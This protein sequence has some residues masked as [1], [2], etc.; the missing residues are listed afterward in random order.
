MATADGYVLLA[1]WSSGMNILHIS[2][3][4]DFD[5][6]GDVDDQDIDL[7]EMC[8]SGPGIAPASGCENRD[9]DNDNDV[10]QSD[11]GLMQRCRS[12]DGILADMD[13]DR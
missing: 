1:D 13:C 5:A 9:L 3:R 12:G 10:D 8:S 4:S 11:F 2:P 6:D 7:F